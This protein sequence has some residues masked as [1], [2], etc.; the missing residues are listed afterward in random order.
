M[1][2][3]ADVGAPAHCINISHDSCFNPQL[4]SPTVT[5]FSL[6][7]LAVVN[8]I[9]AIDIMVPLKASTI[10]IVALALSQ[11]ISGLVVRAPPVSTLAVTSLL[12]G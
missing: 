11:G 6:L 5:F 7:I 3:R 9:K 12:A 8:S 2:A 1:F 10:A 4:Y